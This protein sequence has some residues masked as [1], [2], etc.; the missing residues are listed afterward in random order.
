MVKNLKFDTK[1]CRFNRFN[2][3][4]CRFDPA[5]SSFM[6]QFVMDSMFLTVIKANLIIELIN[7]D[8]LRLINGAYSCFR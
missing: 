7:C 6:L 4:L 8:S 1:H 2:I 5:L 3:S